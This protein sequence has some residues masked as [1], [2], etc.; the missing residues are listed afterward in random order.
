MKYNNA[1]GNIDG[2]K[3]DCSIGT[4]KQILGKRIAYF[5]ITSPKL[6]PSQIDCFSFCASSCRELKV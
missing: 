3:S 6:Y 2:C 5:I 1:L 4:D